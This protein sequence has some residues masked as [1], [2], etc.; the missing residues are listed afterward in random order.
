MRKRIYL[1]EAIA[2]NGSEGKRGTKLTL[3]K[4]LGIT[5][6]AISQWNPRRPLPPHYVYRLKELYPMEFG[7]RE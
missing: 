2:A 3:A 5:R 4:Q 7:N 1:K 6:Q